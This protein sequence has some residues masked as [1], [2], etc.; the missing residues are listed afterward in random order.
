MG[1]ADG[2]LIVGMAAFAPLTLGLGC[3]LELVAFAVL[4]LRGRRDAAVPGALWLYVGDLLG[5]MMCA[6]FR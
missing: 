3:L 4:R 5:A 2:K 1:P 6:I